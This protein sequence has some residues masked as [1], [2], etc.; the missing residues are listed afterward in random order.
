M[1]NRKIRKNE[2]QRRHR[3][4]R[5]KLSGTQQRPRLAVH[6][7]GKHIYAQIIDDVAQHTLCA[8][9]SV[10]LVKGGQ[11]KKGYNVEAAGAVGEAIAQ[12]AIV[13]GIKQVVY[14][15]GGFLY[16]GRIAK[17]AEK[18]RETGLEF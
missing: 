13:G 7:S 14:D 5:M 3:R 12:K 17:L 1:F 18:A 15:R 6:R 11:L 4:L 9:S 16:H 8:A 2:V 10:D